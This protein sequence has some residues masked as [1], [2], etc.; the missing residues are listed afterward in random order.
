MVNIIQKTR[1]KDPVSSGQVSFTSKT[2]RIDELHP[3]L[4]LELL[5]WHRMKASGLSRVD[6]DVTS[7]EASKDPWSLEKDRHREGIRQNTNSKEK[8]R[9]QVDK[10]N[11]G[12]VCC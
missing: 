1:V 10:D 4:S 6:M 2:R 12:D 3:T 8:G 5:G 11:G 7:H 9:L